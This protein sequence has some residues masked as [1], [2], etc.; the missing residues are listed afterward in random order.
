MKLQVLIDK[1]FEGNIQISKPHIRGGFC[2]YYYLNILS[3]SLPFANS[4]T[5]LSRY[6]TCLVIGFLISSNL[7][8][9][10]VPVIK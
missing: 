6:L 5:N 1:K 2:L 3:N 8:P 9:H 4:S 7:L 10:I